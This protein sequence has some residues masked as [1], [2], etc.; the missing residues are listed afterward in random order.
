MELEA[1]TRVD[2]KDLIHLG[3][4]EFKVIHTPGHTKGRNLPLF[5][6]SKMLIFRRY[7]I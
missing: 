2:D 5:W 1:D 4:L 6:K 3:D 7:F